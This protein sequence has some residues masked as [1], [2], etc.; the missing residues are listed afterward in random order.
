MIPCPHCSHELTIEDAKRITFLSRFWSKV[1][2]NGPVVRLDLGPCWIWTASTSGFGYGVFGYG[3]RRGKKQINK[4]AH[5]MAYELLVGPVPDGM[6]LDH[7]CGNR[8]CVNP[9][10]LEPVTHRENIIRAKNFGWDP[11]GYWRS[12]K[13]CPR[14]HEYT[15]ENTLLWRGH[16]TCRECNR[17]RLELRYLLKVLDRSNEKMKSGFDWRAYAWPVK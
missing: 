9:A 16:R 4:S 10:H 15:T 1:D 8:L 5:I 2:R 7:L 17:Q 6:E 11:G 3:R 14:G 13:S 12:K